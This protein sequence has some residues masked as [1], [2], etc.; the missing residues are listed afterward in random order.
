MTNFQT[1]VAGVVTIAVLIFIIEL[2]KVFIN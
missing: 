1:A 2:A